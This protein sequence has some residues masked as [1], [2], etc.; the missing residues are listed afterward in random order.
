MPILTSSLI[1]ILAGLLV[2]GLGCA[3][4][5]RAWGIFWFALV[6]LGGLAALTWYDLGVHAGRLTPLP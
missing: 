2:F 1:G 3:V 5:Q 6:M 4:R